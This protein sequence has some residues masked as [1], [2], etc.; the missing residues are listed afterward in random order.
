MYITNRTLFIVGATSGI[1]LELARRFPAAGST[2]IVGGRRAGTKGPELTPGLE[3][4]HI[5]VADQASID[6][7]RDEILRTRPRLDTIV[8]MAG[9]MLT[10]DLRDPAHFTTAQTIIDINLLGTIRVADAFTPHL[11][12]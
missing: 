7:A 8:T 5:D 11:I 4:I 12:E 2:V 10:E 6:S 1:G 9:V 3:S